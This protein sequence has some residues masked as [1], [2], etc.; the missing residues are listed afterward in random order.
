MSFNINGV[1]DGP[2][3]DSG[4]AHDR[5]DIIADS[6]MIGTE[7]NDGDVSRSKDGHRTAYAL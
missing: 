6:E 5:S 2:E 3:H 4:I 7:V 1:E